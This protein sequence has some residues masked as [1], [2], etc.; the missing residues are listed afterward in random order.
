MSKL[1]ILCVFV[2]LG[3]V[4]PFLKYFLQQLYN[5]GVSD[6]L[7]VGLGLLVSIDQ[8]VQNMVNKFRI[9][10]DKKSI[11]LGFN[12]KLA[13]VAGIGFLLALNKHPNIG[14]PLAFRFRIR[15]LKIVEHI[16]H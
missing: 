12:G 11:D 2:F 13:S 8:S 9:E 7:G 6:G 16:T 1:K 10:I 15:F 5:F 4:Q 3:Y 14:L